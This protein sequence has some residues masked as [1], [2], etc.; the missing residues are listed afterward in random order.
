MT[1][2]P[3]LTFTI[4]WSLFVFVASRSAAQV[5]RTTANQGLTAHYGWLDPQS[6]DGVNTIS[7]PQAT[8]DITLGQSV[9][10]YNTLGDPT[11]GTNL[12][13]TDNNY[14]VTFKLFASTPT[15][16]TG[17]NATITA[18]LTTEYSINGGT[19]TSVGG[20]SQVIASRST[21]GVTT[22]TQVFTVTLNF[23][24]GGPDWIRLILTA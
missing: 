21:P 14:T 17:Q 6:G 8:G 1:R 3:G 15:L 13:A 10:L 5:P 7:F 18:Y 12:P 4:L 20:T 9:R 11:A 23:S 24:G 2:S 16:G 22:T 19:Y